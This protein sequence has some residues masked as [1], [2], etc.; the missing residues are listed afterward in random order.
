MFRWGLVGVPFPP[1]LL[2]PGK[3]SC[4]ENVVSP[5]PVTP[6]VGTGVLAGVGVSVGVGVEVVPPAG[7]V[8]VGVACGA[9]VGVGVVQGP[10]SLHVYVQSLLTVTRATL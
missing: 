8:G 6:P 7:G 5:V 10:S 9:D 1:V 2:I 4:I 3:V